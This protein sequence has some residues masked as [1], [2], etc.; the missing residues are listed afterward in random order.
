MYWDGRRRRWIA[1]KTVGYDARGKRVRRKA[2][3]TS[4]S[5]A[6][7]ELRRRVKDYERGLVVH[8]EWFTVKQAVTDWYNHGQ[9]GLD[10][11]TQRKNRDLCDLYVIP[12][13]GGRRLRDLQAEE[14][15]HWLRLLAED[16][17]TSTLQHTKSALSRSIRRA[18]ARGYVDRNVVE[19][20]QTPKGQAGRPSKALT[21]DQARD[22]LTLSAGDALYCYIVVSLLTGARTEEL[23]ALLWTNVHLGDPDSSDSGYIEVWRS[24]R[25][26]GDTKTRKSRRTLALPAL[27]VSALRQ[28]RGHQATVMRD[29]AEWADLGLVFTTS[30]GTPL[31][32]ANVRR[33]FRRALRLVNDERGRV[34]E[35]ANEPVVPVLDPD[36]WT[37]RE[38]RHSFVSLLSEHGIPI[39]EIARLVGHKGGSQVTERI[40]RKQ[41]RPVIQ[42]G[43][44]TM[45]LIFGDARNRS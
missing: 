27:A 39:E 1:E 32:A 15:D 14:V 30:I 6:L 12:H 7:N 35:A 9:T 43:A 4:R 24:V 21:L 20:C 40:Y 2:S 17:A 11:N 19:L 5:A 10:Q 18:I 45:D 38:M 31:D 44:T 8:S 25:H 34:Q 29:A 13:L 16:L 22:V 36:E 26:G 42:T 28:H 41:I 37:P 33:D 3:G 23:R